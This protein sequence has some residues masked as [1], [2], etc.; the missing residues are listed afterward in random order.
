MSPVDGTGGGRPRGGL[1]AAEHGFSLVEMLL[2]L[3]LGALLL[4]GLLG[5]VESTGASRRVAAE[6]AALVRDAGYAMDRMARAVGAARVLLVPTPDRPATAGDESVREPGVLVVTDDP[7]A[8]RDRDGRADADND[9]DGRIDEDTGND[10]TADA[11]AGVVGVD[12]DGDGLVDEGS[13]ND[14][15]EDGLTNEDPV[16]GVDDDG[17]GLV[18]EDPDKDRENDG[19]PGLAGV[20][21]DGDGLT[22]E[23]PKSDDDED[24]RNNEE[25]LEPVVFRLVGDTLLE[26][27]PRP[28]ALAG[29]AFYEHT[30]L[31]GVTRL[32]VARLAPAALDRALLVHIELEV[33]AASG[34]R[35]A[36]ERRVRL[37]AGG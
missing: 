18:D 33:T 22:D 11:A 5:V 17:D 14:D 7:R 2:A 20:D 12:D 19:A 23:G 37:G 10:L 9:G 27:M 21:D 3:A 26:R 32:R 25:W 29:G 6:R 34:E 8:D 36:L 31:T 30:L 24:G 13:D 15:D 4:A 16:N 35:I 28:G 1:P